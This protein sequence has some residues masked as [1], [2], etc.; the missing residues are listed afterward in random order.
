MVNGVDGRGSCVAVQQ[1]PQVT[2]I[3]FRAGD[4]EFCPA[5]FSGELF[6]LGSVDVLGVG[7]EAE[8]QAGELG[9][10][11]CHGG[12]SVAEMGVQML[13]RRVQELSRRQVPGLEKM[14]HRGGLFPFTRPQDRSGEAL[15]VMTPKTLPEQAIALQEPSPVG[16][17]V[18]GHIAYG[19][20]DFLHVLVAEVLPRLP[21]GKDPDGDA[22][23]FQEQDFSADEGFG[24]AGIALEDHTQVV[25]IQVHFCSQRLWSRMRLRMTSRAVKGNCPI[26]RRQDEPLWRRVRTFSRSV[27]GVNSRGWR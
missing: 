7:G 22:E 1:S 17:N 23:R 3:V 5:D 16:K 10:E 20:L 4:N 25:G 24:N 9:G 21:Q 14:A 2:G 27:A 13:D 26:F 6:G 11:I 12:G 18:F 15:H 8:G 19:G